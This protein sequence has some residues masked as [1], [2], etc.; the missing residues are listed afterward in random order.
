MYVDTLIA[1]L[2]IAFLLYR[3]VK[4]KALGNLGFILPL[5]MVM[6]LNTDLP[7]MMPEKVFVAYRLVILVSCVG[8]FLFYLWDFRRRERREREARL[9]A[10]EQEKEARKAR[11]KEANAHP[12]PAKRKKKKRK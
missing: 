4:T 11:Q 12:N 1:V 6:L 10:L 2:F 5:V 8:A 9:T 3:F 7:Q